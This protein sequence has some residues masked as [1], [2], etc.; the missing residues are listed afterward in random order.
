MIIEFEPKKMLL[1]Y[2]PQ[3]WLYYKAEYEKEFKKISVTRDKL[4]MFLEKYGYEIN[5]I[6]EL[7][8]FG[9]DT[10]NMLHNRNL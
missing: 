7:K 9:V 1:S 6:I 5:D 10:V 2:P 8:N 4:I 3:Y